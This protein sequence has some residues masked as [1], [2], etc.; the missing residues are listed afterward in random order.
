M[1]SLF[2]LPETYISEMTGYVGDVFTD[3]K[4]LIILGIGLPM[5]FYIIKKL[6][7]LAPR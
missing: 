2:I 3:A 7:A 5:G 6:I 4:L 1:L